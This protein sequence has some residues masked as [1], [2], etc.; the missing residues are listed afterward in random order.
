MAANMAEEQY[1]TGMGL[2]THHGRAFG[3]IAFDLI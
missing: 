2:F 3:Q 1:Y